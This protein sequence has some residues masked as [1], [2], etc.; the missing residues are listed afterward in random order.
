MGAYLSRPET[1]KETTSQSNEW[2]SY[3]CSSMQGWRR[4]QEVSRV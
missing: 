3:G 4:F 2:T 1:D